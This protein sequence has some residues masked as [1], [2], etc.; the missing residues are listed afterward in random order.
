MVIYLDIK[1]LIIF[2]IKIKLKFSRLKCSSYNFFK[3]SH[4]KKKKINFELSVGKNF[5][6][7]LRKF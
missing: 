4:K 3:K 5:I 1:N 7:T 6:V 2:L